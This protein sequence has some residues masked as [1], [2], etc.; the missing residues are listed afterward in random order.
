MS[1]YP[2]LEPV[3]MGADHSPSLYDLFDQ[4]K[5]ILKQEAKSSSP[6]DEAPHPHLATPMGDAL[7]NV[8]VSVEAATAT[9]A[10]R[11]GETLLFIDGCGSSTV[12]VTTGLLTCETELADAA[13]AVDRFS[14]SVTAAMKTSV[15]TASATVEDGHASRSQVLMHYKEI[16][17]TLWNRLAKARLQVAL[18]KEELAQYKNDMFLLGRCGVLTIGID[19]DD[20]DDGE[21]YRNVKGQAMEAAG[22]GLHAPL[23]TAPPVAGNAAERMGFGRVTGATRQLMDGVVRRAT[24]SVK[25]ATAHADIAL[26]RVGAE[27]GGFAAVVGGGGGAAAAAAGEPLPFRGHYAAQPMELSSAEE[28]ALREENESLQLQQRAASAQDARAVERA[29]RELSQLTSIMNER[30]VEQ[31]EQFTTMIKHTEEAHMNMEKA[32]KEVKKPIH[33]FWNPT[34]Q[35]IALLWIC[36]FILIVANWMIR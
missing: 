17:S 35:M 29:V 34:R 26:T 5:Q 3:L 4:G 28:R 18:A 13:A 10:R 20:D 30:V 31:S 36:T 23:K 11:V 7:R 1:G 19:D 15:S 12:R 16:L 6:A 27:L 33:A 9:A 25:V 32:I 2:P 24:D 8:Q 21:D 22:G 14:E